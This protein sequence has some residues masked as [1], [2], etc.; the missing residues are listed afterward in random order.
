M[1]R[2]FSSA[3]NTE[4]L[5]TPSAAI[6][7]NLSAFTYA[8]WV[9][10]TG[11]GGNNTGVIITKD[12]QGYGGGD[13]IVLYITG[14]ADLPHSPAGALSGIVF[15]AVSLSNTSIPLNSWTHIAMTRDFAG[16]KKVHLFI[17]G[18]EVAYN[19][20]YPI[21]GA[22]NPGDAALGFYIG[23]DLFANL[24][25][26]AFDG[27]IAEVAVW[28][29]VLSGA[30]ILAAATSTNGV[31]GVAS[32]NLVGYWHL[33]GTLSPEPDA[34]GNGNA[35]VLSAIPPTQGS[36]SPGNA[37][38]SALAVVLTSGTGVFKKSIVKSSL[39]L[40]FQL[41]V[42][43][44]GRLTTTPYPKPP[45]SITIPFF[46]LTDSSGQTW[47]IDVNSTGQ[48][49]TT[50]VA[51]NSAAPTFLL[52]PIPINSGGN[53]AMLTVSTSGILQTQVGGVTTWVQNG[54]GA[55]TDN[56]IAGGGGG[57]M[58][59]PQPPS[60]SGAFNPPNTGG[61]FDLGNSWNGRF[62][63]TSQTLT[64]GGTWSVINNPGRSA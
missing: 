6:Y 43:V 3:Q 40:Y 59:L 29:T 38:T 54:M 14:D 20:P 28:N 4:V 41:G 19:S 15:D 27:N 5:I 2:V 37:C 56:S 44:Q 33:C 49:T 50:Q 18:T 36:D 23:N 60:P 46:I 34:T 10:P 48:L 25:T 31:A 55:G 45:S 21:V 53:V 63:S 8:A 22:D 62:G 47:Q 57:F 35:A 26:S 12:P 16:D 30:Q 11:Y 39:G 17:N 61:S 51:Y 42:D 24:N 9:Y 32:A 52:L 58:A 7:N 13:A 64:S 1:S